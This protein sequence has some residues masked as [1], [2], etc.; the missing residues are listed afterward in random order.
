MIKTFWMSIELKTWY[1]MDP[2][3]TV[4]LQYVWEDGRKHIKG[5]ECRRKTK[6]RPDSANS[7]GA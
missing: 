1:V 6:T 7:D 5:T 4:T 2:Y 3:G